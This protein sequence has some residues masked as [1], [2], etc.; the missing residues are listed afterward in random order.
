MAS[1]IIFEDFDQFINH[2]S[3]DIVTTNSSEISK[4]PIIVLCDASG[5]TTTSFDKTKCIFL[6]QAQILISSYPERFFRFIFWTSEG[7]RSTNFINGIWTFDYITSNV[8]QLFKIVFAS[9]N[10]FA[11][12]KPGLA[13]NAITKEQYNHWFNKNG[14]TE[15]V[16]ITDGNVDTGHENIL[17]SAIKNLFSKRDNLRLY[18]HA[19]ESKSRNY[20]SSDEMNNAAGCDVARIIHKNN[21][22]NYVSNFKSHNP[23]CIDG[24]SHMSRVIVPLGHVPYG[25]HYFPRTEEPIFFNLLVKYVSDNNSD[26]NHIRVIQNLVHTIKKLVE[27]LTPY[28]SSELLHRYSSIF[29][30]DN[31][32]IDP[33]LATIMLKQAIDGTRTSDLIYSDY[34]ARMNQLYKEVNILLQSSNA[35]QVLGIRRNAVSYL[36]GNTIF[37][38]D[39]SLIDQNISV[40]GTTFQNIGIS[41]DDFTCPVFSTDTNHQFMTEQA[42]RQFTRSMVIQILKTHNIYVDLKCDTLMYIVMAMASRVCY[43]TS[44]P[45]DIKSSYRYLAKIMLGKKRQSTEQTEL[46]RLLQG[47]FPLPNN[48]K[49]DDFYKI[50][51]NCCSYLDIQVSDPM[52]IWY[53]MCQSIDSELAKKQLSHCKQSIINCYG[54]I[55][56]N[57]I[58]ILFASTI[59]I[60]FYK[61][62]K[63]LNPICPVTHENISC[64]GGMMIDSHIIGNTTCDPRFVIGLNV[65]DSYQKNRTGCK[66]CFQKN[67][68]YTKIG[69]FS[70]NFTPKI[71]D[72]HPKPFNSSYMKDF[73]DIKSNPSSST[74][75]PNIN[76]QIMSSQSSHITDTDSSSSRFTSNQTTNKRILIVGKGTVGCGKTTIF[77][78]LQK[79]VQSNG[80]ECYVEG[81]DKYTIR[82][83]DP[84][85]ASSMVTSEL[86][87]AKKSKA[88]L[89]VV[90]IDTCGINASHKMF[91]VDFNGW[92]RHDIMVNLPD[93]NQKRIREYLSWSLRNVLNRPMYDSYSKFYLNSISA[94]VSICLK[95]HSDKAKAILQ[96][97]F[98]NVT[99]K[100]DKQSILNDIN[101]AANEYQLF[102]NTC[103]PLEKTVRDLYQL[104]ETTAPT[105]EVENVP[106]FQPLQRSQ[107]VVHST[108]SA[109]PSTTLITDNEWEVITDS[110]PI[111]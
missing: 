63:S 95:V 78:E 22:E 77:T 79:L 39:A 9:K 110:N 33:A 42:L 62:N 67:I 3:A 55:P 58:N 50:M 88:N 101:E 13:F 51:S 83:V 90:I 107:T 21:L 102:L 104:I 66:D 98:V 54:E 1:S 17:S 71:S 16:Y 59:F 24:F 64:M 36:I 34:R 30:F 74:Q 94:G 26:D 11:S 44:I 56:S 40:N 15:I 37:Y 31:C 99:S 20:S 65:F 53:A 19:V 73:S 23:K 87:K 75:I 18:I 84:R 81:T 41:I 29:W 6:A 76:S 60:N 93:M 85:C 45:E 52:I 108:I 96:H 48:G 100:Y 14:I 109:N 91:Q 105:I 86:E 47:E 2:Y 68:T 12:T 7:N 80:G 61:I 89:V 46:A 10:E 69:P 92:T 38:V 57:L 106:K 70:D 111:F 82:G 35:R 72:D 32:K 4:F 43:N 27:D 28:L 5:S 103:H 8:D 25:S 97:K 49:I